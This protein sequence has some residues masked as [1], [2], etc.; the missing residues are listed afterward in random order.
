MQT[1]FKKVL[2]L[3]EYL[4]NIGCQLDFQSG[5]LLDGFLP[6]APRGLK[7]HHIEN[8]K[9]LVLCIVIYIMYFSLQNVKINGKSKDYSYVALIILE[10]SVG[11]IIEV[12][13]APIAATS[14]G[15]IVYTFS[16]IVITVGQIIVNEIALSRTEVY[17]K[18]VCDKYNLFMIMKV[19]LMCLEAVIILLPIIYEVVNF[20]DDMEYVC[21]TS[22][23]IL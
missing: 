10:I 1:G 5:A 17:G 14:R 15:M 16:C 20:L 7:I 18:Y 4:I 22:M 23:L 11:V 9:V 12:S 13:L 8:K 19:L 6:K 2:N 21:I 3:R